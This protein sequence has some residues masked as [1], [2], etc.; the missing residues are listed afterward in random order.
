MLRLTEDENSTLDELAETLSRDPALSAKLL[1]LSNSSL[2]NLGQEI[3]SLQRS[4]MVLGMKT[5]KLMSLSFSLIGTLPKEGRAGDFDFGEYWRRS[6][7]S[8]VVA[9]S[10]AKLVGNPDGD[11]AFLCGLLGYL[12][13]LVLARCMPDEYGEVIEA[14]GTWPSLDAEEAKLGFDSADVGGALLKE[15]GLPQLVYA[16]LAYAQR[17]D[18]EPDGLDPRTCDLLKLMRITACAE[19]VLC[20]EEKGMPLQRMHELGERDFDLGDGQIDAFLVG[21]ES[22]IN[23]AA[24]M[25]SVSMPQG[26]SHE[27]IVGQARMQIVNISLGTAVDLHQ[28]KRRS[29]ALEDETRDLRTKATTDKLTG[30][31]NRA[32]F[33]ETLDKHLRA[34][35][36]GKTPRALGLI[37]IDID[38]FKK[39]NDTYGHQTGDEALRLVG[40]ALMTVTRKGDVA[41]RYGGEEFVLIAPQT[42]P[43]GLRTLSERLREEIARQVLEVDGEQLSVTASLGAACITTVESPE[44]GGLLVKL[45]DRFLYRAKENGR[46]RCEVY[47]RVQLPGR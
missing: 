40:S 8:A 23:E 38:H 15:W 2:F 28:E 42:T 47:P 30:L 22:G 1:K 24:D 43:F 33:D 7:I 32:A 37:M 16:S 13:K 3:T 14:G 11:E 44:D 12:G 17:P 20:N 10:L 39:F 18:L 31:P 46:N 34:R 27:D 19:A 6:L 25:L 45:A 4:T 35:I 9:R 36:E 41:A 29:A 26:L 21:L 5:V